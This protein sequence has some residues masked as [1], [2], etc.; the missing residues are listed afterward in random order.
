MCV[1]AVFG[2]VHG[3]GGLEAPIE[4]RALKRTCTYSKNISCKYKNSV[5]I[6]PYAFI[7]NILK[8]RN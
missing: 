5:S 3:H 8:E 7:I 1:T 2:F 6:H 4:F